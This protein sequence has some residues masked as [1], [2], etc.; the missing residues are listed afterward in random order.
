MLI[1]GYPPTKVDKMW[2]VDQIFRSMFELSVV[3]MPQNQEIFKN[4]QNSVSFW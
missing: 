1:V 4:F 2:A 3:P